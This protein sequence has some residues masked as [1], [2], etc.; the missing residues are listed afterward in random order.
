MYIVVIAKQC[1]IPCIVVGRVVEQKQ[2]IN[3]CVITI[4][5][6]ANSYSYKI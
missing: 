4:D 6:R 1:E 5:I 2:I 3:A